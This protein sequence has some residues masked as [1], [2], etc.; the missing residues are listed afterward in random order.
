MMRE[1]VNPGIGHRMF[2]GVW[3]GRSRLGDRFLGFAMLLSPPGND[4]NKLICHALIM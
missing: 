4:R 1:R 2:Y 3:P